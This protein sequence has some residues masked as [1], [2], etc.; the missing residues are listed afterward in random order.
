MSR[1][2]LSDLS[3][4][5]AVDGDVKRGRPPRLA[6]PDQ[7]LATVLHLRVALAA[8]PLAVLF[9]SSRTAMHR[10]LLKIRT[11]LKA[12]SVII[13]PAATLPSALTALQA[14]GSSPERRPSVIKTT[15]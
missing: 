7:V 14:R 10:T 11:L 2:Q 13:P 5:L 3:D 9:D 4:T 6:F 1:Q 15:C 8:E 12:H